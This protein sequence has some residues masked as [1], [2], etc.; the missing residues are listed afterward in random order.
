M[1]NP[2]EGFIATANNKVIGNHYPYHISHHWAQ[3][4]RYMR[5]AQVL[6]SKNNLHDRRHEK[7]ANGS[8][9][10]MGE[11][12]CAGIGASGGWQTAFQN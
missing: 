5:I 2:K 7:A 1:V 3:P 9:Q 12:I 4:Y 10:L 6:E 8:N 11:R